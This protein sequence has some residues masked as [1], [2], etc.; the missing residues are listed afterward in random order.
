M[1]ARACTG[2]GGYRLAALVLAAALLLVPV[3]V[4]RAQNNVLTIGATTLTFPTPGVTEFDNGFSAATSVSFT[5]DAT[6]G[7]GGIRRVTTVKVYCQSVTGGKPCS[8]VQ[9]RLT[10]PVTTAWTD[11]TSVAPGAVVIERCIQ[12]NNTSPPTGC[13]VGTTPVGEPYSGTMELRTK[14]S[15]TAD[16]QATYAATIRVTLEVYQ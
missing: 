16:A 1:R 7:G 12:R 4:T 11:M 2:V 8:D 9:W 13:P 5:V 10:T 6:T 14:L 15:W 3:G